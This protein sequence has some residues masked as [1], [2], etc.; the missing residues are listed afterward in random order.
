VLHLFLGGAALADH[1]LLDLTGCV[2]VHRHIAV[3]TGTDGRAACLSELQRGIRVLVHKHLLNA[4]F[5]GPVLVDY[6]TQFREDDAQSLRQRVA[7]GTD[8]AAGGIAELLPLLVDDPV[9]RYP[10]TG[11]YTEDA[12]HAVA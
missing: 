7:P 9:A 1:G 4:H 6:G 8:T 2:F 11:V 12:C 3:Y 10:G 5:I